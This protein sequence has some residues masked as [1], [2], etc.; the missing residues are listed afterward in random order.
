MS[1]SKLFHVL[2]ISNYMPNAYTVFVQNS[3]AI[4]LLENKIVLK[5]VKKSHNGALHVL[6]TT[7]QQAV[8]SLFYVCVVV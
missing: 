8:T 5:T 7:T 2:I 1:V 3:A 4:R 6:Q